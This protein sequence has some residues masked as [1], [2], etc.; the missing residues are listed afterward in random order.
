MV[1]VAAF[2][3]LLAIIS[4]TAGHCQVPDMRKSIIEMPLK[5]S[6][7]PAPAP[8][9][10]AVIAEPQ[11]AKVPAGK[12]RWHSDAAKASKAA[13]LSGKP[14]LLFAMLGNLDDRFC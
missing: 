10:V 7:A 12:V 4:G 6:I 1:R 14:V 13:Q 9:P 3:S 5:R 8:A 11:G 2:L